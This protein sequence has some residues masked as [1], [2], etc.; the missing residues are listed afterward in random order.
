MSYNITDTD[1][2]SECKMPPKPCSELVKT[3]VQ[4]DPIKSEQSTGLKAHLRSDHS[5]HIPRCSGPH[6]GC[7]QMCLGSHRST[8][9]SIDDL[10]EITKSIQNNREHVCTHC[11]I[12]CF[13]LVHCNTI[14]ALLPAKVSRRCL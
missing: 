14:G 7:T 13:H 12:H 5:D 9:Y 2:V 3:S 11:A 6:T 1:N 4:S 8:A 10:C